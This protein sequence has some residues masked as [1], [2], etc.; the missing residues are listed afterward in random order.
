[1][2]TFLGQEAVDRLDSVEDKIDSLDPGKYSNA[3]LSG[4]LS[5]A[6]KT[7]DER[8]KKV[9]ALEYKLDFALAALPNLGQY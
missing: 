6:F 2:L 4:Q 5:A 3:F 1:M 9:W 7:L 8:S